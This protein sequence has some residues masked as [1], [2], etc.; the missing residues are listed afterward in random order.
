MEGIDIQRAIM[1][2]LKGVQELQELVKEQATEI[3]QLKEIINQ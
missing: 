1:L 3:K 2:G